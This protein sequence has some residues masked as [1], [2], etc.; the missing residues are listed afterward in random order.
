MGEVVRG[1]LPG[2]EHDGEFLVGGGDRPVAGHQLIDDVGEHL[3]VVV[4]AGVGV[5]DQR[6]PAVAGDDHAQPDQ[7]QVGALLLG[8]PALGDRRLLIAGIDVGGEVGHVQRHAGK[9]EAELGRH[10]RRQPPLDPGQ[11][12]LVQQVHRIPEPPVVQRR[13][14]HA[15]QAVPG[16]GGPP[17]R[18]RA[19]G[20]RRDYPVR[21]RQREVGARRCGRVRAPLP[22]HLI[23]DRGVAQPLQYPPGRGQVPERQVPGPLRLARPGLAEPGRDLLR[24]PQVALGDDPRLAA[25]PRGLHQ[26]VVGPPALLLRHQARHTSR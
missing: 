11:R 10:R 17:V 9:A 22:G 2:V 26:V 18:E 14:R 25:D 19:L 21:A 5:A 16:G 4:V 20:P 7:P 23:D 3:H 12:R 8:V 1:V 15:R 6:D 24:R 13:P